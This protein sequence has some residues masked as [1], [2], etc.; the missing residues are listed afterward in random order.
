M[1][2]HEVAALGAEI[3]EWRVRTA[4]RTA[5]DI[6][7]VP[8]EPL[9]LPAFAP[10]DID[11]RRT[12]AAAFRERWAAIDVSAE[13]V[14]VQVDHR[15]LG[16]VLAR[17]DWECDGLPSWRFDAHFLVGQV[18]GPY[19]DLLLARP[20]FADDR[21]ASILNALQAIP[22]QIIQA[23][24][25][26]DGHGVADLARIAIGELDGIEGRLTASVAALA[27]QHGTGF[28][29]ERHAAASVA[30]AIAGQALAGFR[31]WLQDA[32]PGFGPSV[33]IGRD[34]FVHYLRTV[35]LIAD[36]PEALVAAAEQ[37][38]RR[39]V[40]WEALAKNAHPERP[41]PFAGIDEQLARQRADEQAM[42]DFAEA[43]NLLSQA[44]F[45][46]YHVHPVPAYVEPLHWFGVNDDL[47]GYDRAGEDGLAYTPDPGPGLPYFY[48]ANAIDPRLG[49]IHE[50]A[51]YQQL[52]R[53]WAH[54]DALRRHYYDSTA[55]EGIAFY[56]EEMML[57]AGL[58]DDAPA[59]RNV[60][61]NFNRLRSLRVVVDV[62][63]AT[64]AFTLEEGVQTFVSRVPMD[65]ATAREE[66]AFYL[67][68]PGLGMSYL[69]GKLQLM[70][71]LA[72][73]I[74]SSAGTGEPFDFRAFHD[75]VW[76]NGNLP[77]S[78]Q[79]WELLGDRS[80]VDVLDAAAAAAAEVLS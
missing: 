69:V 7:R 66:T 42:R 8:H 27:S 65:D 54:E 47:T 24:E 56:N 17:A 38:Y 43:A 73:A 9:W 53:A 57:Q 14:P 12:A 34:A 10:A 21:Q 1:S 22:A 44:G 39:A 28:G 48:A 40:V 18:V 33:A 2:A 19:F 15:L 13:P 6:P 36:E 30:A 59:S 68:T 46:H 20:P 77:F 16:S 32:L 37:E 60:V 63:L 55:N 52:V 5:D 61:H 80:E 31:D 64:G 79:R 49:I 78:L 74:E 76:K 45:G 50:G 72:D 51:H 71:M 26:L 11:A 3:W 62:S 70:R 35:A 4:F 23:R 58:F 29:A 75:W 67:A 41:A 25:N